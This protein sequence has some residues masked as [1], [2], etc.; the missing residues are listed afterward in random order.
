[1]GHCLATSDLTHWA[2]M[3]WGC[4][5]QKHFSSR[6]ALLKKC[7]PFL[8]WT[9]LWANTFV[10]IFQGFE[11]SI[12]HNIIFHPPVCISK[13]TN[14]ARHIKW[15]AGL[16]ANI[17]GWNCSQEEIKNTQYREIHLEVRKIFKGI[18]L[19]NLSSVTPS[20]TGKA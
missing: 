5:Q 4:L 17:D 16:L 10:F 3:F 18:I 7:P 9:A 15:I 11:G 1:M 13:V 14:K 2:Y 19:L 12:P 6:V 20:N 8:L